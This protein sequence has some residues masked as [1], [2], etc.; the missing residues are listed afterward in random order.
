MLSW[1][2]WS[3]VSYGALV[4][5]ISKEELCGVQAASGRKEWHFKLGVSVT[6]WFKNFRYAEYRVRENNLNKHV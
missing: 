3:L 4:C 1:L 5:G 2:F 6:Q